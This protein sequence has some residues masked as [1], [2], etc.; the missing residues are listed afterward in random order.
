MIPHCEW[1]VIERLRPS[2][3]VVAEGSQASVL[4]H[5]SGFS[6][7]RTAIDKWR[8]GGWMDGWVRGKWEA[9]KSHIL[10]SVSKGRLTFYMWLAII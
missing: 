5:Q 8:M 7:Y 3:C 9:W 1:Y 2:R 4:L 10:S 6:R